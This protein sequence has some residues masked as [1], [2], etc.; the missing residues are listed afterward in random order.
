MALFADEAQ[1]IN[2]GSRSD[3][4]YTK[5]KSSVQAKSEFYQP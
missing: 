2:G 5:I 1:S 3:L 4:V